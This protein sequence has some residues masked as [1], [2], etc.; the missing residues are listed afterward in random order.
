MPKDYNKK[1]CDKKEKNSN[2][3]QGNIL[4]IKQI[5]DE[6]DRSNILKGQ[7]EYVEETHNESCYGM[8]EDRFSLH[9]TK[10]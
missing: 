5:Q 2:G 7:D 9:K 8:S 10:K 3:K 4:K 6:A 1:V